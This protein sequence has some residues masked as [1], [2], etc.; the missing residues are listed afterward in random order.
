MKADAIMKAIGKVEAGSKAEEVLSSLPEG[1]KPADLPT[2]PETEA[3]GPPE[4]TP[5]VEAGGRPD[6]TPPVDAG[7]PP[8]FDAATGLPMVAMDKTP[9]GF[10]AEPDSSGEADEIL[11]FIF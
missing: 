7:G 4:V 8:M 6:M 5:P 1:G 3:M 11:E 2:M 9:E 10:P